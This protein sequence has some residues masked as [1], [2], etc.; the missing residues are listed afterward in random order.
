MR[1]NLHYFVLIYNSETPKHYKTQNE[2]IKEQKKN[3]EDD[4]II[5]AEKNILRQ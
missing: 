1:E 5:R 2:F 3:T 4:G